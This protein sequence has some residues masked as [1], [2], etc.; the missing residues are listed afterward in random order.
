M[1]NIFLIIAGF[2]LFFLV[3][4]SCNED[5]TIKEIIKTK[6]DT[7]FVIKEKLVKITDTLPI[8]KYETK[9]VDKEVLKFIMVEN[10]QY[11][12]KIDTN[13]SYKNSN[14]N[15]KINGWGTIS[16]I[17]LATTMSDTSYIVNKEITK[18]ILKPSK[19]LYLSPEYIT[20][21]KVDELNNPL[22]RVNLDYINGSFII[23]TGVGIQNNNPNISLKIGYKIR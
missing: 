17:E 10:K 5:K 9:Y 6:I 13:Y 12:Y 22:Y 21:F 1:K 20:P 3:V 14:T 23:G 15:L 4:K 11:N 7:T 19:G 2:L 8:V 18:T 16:K